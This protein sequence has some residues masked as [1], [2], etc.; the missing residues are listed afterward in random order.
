MTLRTRNLLLTV[1]GTLSFVLMLLV[2][3]PFA[4]AAVVTGVGVMVFSV[5]R[6]GAENRQPWP[7]NKRSMTLGAVGFTGGVVLLALA[8]YRP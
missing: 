4:L 3:A 2:V 5:G 1:G 8:L 7:T 6:D